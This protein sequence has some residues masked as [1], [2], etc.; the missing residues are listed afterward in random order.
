MV[1]ARGLYYVKSYHVKSCHHTIWYYVIWY[2]IMLSYIYTLYKYLLGICTRNNACIPEDGM[3]HQ[4]KPSTN[5]WFNIF[6]PPRNVFY[7][8]I[9]YILCVRVP[10]AY[11]CCDV[12]HHSCMQWQAEIYFKNNI[13][14]LQN[15][16]NDD[17][18]LRAFA[19][20]LAAFLLPIFR[21]P[22]S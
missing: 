22:R 13:R 21:G 17:R 12:L 1:N 20:G 2:L 8:Y 4:H 19:T 5:H 15:S 7:I 14:N 9:L 10:V 6:W 16:F 18:S 3:N 11:M